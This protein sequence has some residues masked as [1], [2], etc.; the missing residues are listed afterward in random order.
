M[1][2]SKSKLERMLSEKYQAGR[3]AGETWEREYNKITAKNEVDNIC[4]T[5]E[6]IA[7]T[8]KKSDRIVACERICVHIRNLF[9]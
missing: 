7:L 5:I 3:E 2:I 4:N 6:T 1:F 9:E 8:G